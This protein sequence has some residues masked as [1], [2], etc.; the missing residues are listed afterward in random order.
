MFLEIFTLVKIS[1]LVLVLGGIP[2]NFFV[3]D[4]VFFYGQLL[5]AGL[6]FVEYF[7]WSPVFFMGKLRLWE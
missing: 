4:F 3:T 7:F 2:G 6:G 1:K 5:E